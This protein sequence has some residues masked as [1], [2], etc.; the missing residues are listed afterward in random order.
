M[1]KKLLV[2]GVLGAFLS[3]CGGGGG[4]GSSSPGGLNEKPTDFALSQTSA[5]MAPFK[6]LEIKM[7]AGQ[8]PYRIT[9]S[10]PQVAESSVSS[11]NDDSFFIL[12]KFAPSQSTATINVVDGRAKSLTVQVSIATS[13]L[14]V[15]P[16]NI[17][18]QVGTFVPISVYGGSSPYTLASDWPGQFILPSAPIGAGQVNIQVSSA[19]LTSTAQIIVR[20]AAGQTVNTSVSLSPKTAIVSAVQ[21]FPS[22]G[23]AGTQTLGFGGVGDPSKATLSIQLSSAYV[24]SPRELRISRQS[25]SFS[26]AP[27]VVT[28]DSSGKAVTFIQI[29]AA[30]AITEQALLSITDTQT[31]EVF[32]YSFTITGKPLSITPPNYSF[33]GL[34]SACSSDIVGVMVSGGVPPYKVETR[35]SEIVTVNPPVLTT[36]GQSFIAQA[37]GRCT[38]TSPGI[39]VVTDSANVTVQFQAFNLRDVST[40]PLK[41]T[42]DA[43][44]VTCAS[45]RGIQLNFTIVGGKGPYTLS[46]AIPSVVAPLQGSKPAAGPFQAVLGGGYGMSSIVV[47]DSTGQTALAQV[48]VVAP[49]P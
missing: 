19:L 16:S 48:T 3:A 25:G 1:F 27:Q 46:G 26:V 28:T 6:S 8:A 15:S 13:T 7:I 18:A 21:L 40:S 37:T 45:C 20:D 9:S 42:P 22:N 14:A 5:A 49:A 2:A 23:A 29:D 43:A 12:S 10:N 30:A 33:L 35:N 32:S 24:S 47:V 4:S 38:D 39:I 36:S 17:S 31:G 41:L 11:T 44:T 34:G